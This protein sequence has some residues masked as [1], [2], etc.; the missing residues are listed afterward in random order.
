MP[1][2]RAGE[3]DTGEKLPD[4]NGRSGASPSRGWRTGTRSWKTRGDEPAGPLAEWRPRAFVYLKVLGIS[5]ASIHSTREC[6]RHH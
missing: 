5:G 2:T 1:F 6:Q 3:G 4:G